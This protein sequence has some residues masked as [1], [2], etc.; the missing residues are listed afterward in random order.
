V[1][2]VADQRSALERLHPRRATG[3]RELAHRNGRLAEQAVACTQLMLA[4]EEC[5]RH[6]ERRVGVRLDA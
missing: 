3:T 4:V 5:A 2:G 1:R 6:R